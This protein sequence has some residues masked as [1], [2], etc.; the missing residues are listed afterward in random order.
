M[1][2]DFLKTCFFCDEDWGDCSCRF[3]GSF[4]FDGCEIIEPNVDE[5]GRFFVNP[6]TYY[7]AVYTSGA[8]RPVR[9]ELCGE[10]DD[11]LDFV[12]VEQHAHKPEGGFLCAGCR[13]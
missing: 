8:C 3:V 10:N 7:G 12:A 11:T 4:D 5:T 13:S 1:P 9:C 6:I 2:V